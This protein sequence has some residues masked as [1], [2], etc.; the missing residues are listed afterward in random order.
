VTERDSVASMAATAVERFGRIDILCANAGIYPTSISLP[1]P[2]PV[3]L[4]M[5]IN[6]RG[7]LFAIQACLRRWRPS[8]TG[9][10]C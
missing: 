6:V 1:S 2:P 4:V 7:A 9:A 10:S 3:G 5:D 8:I